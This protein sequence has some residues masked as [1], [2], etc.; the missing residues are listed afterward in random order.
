MRGAKRVVIELVAPEGLTSDGA[1]LVLFYS[2]SV[3]AP[4]GGQS[5][6]V[7]TRAF[8]TRSFGATP[9]GGLREER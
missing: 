7:L 2:R 8:E 3:E 6:R 4:W 1:Q 5:P 9:T